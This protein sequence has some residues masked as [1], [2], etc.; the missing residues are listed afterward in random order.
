MKAADIYYGLSSREVRKFA[1]QY[2]KILKRNI[3]KS[4]HDKEIAGVDWFTL[5]L[6]RHRN[7]S[8]RK[9]EATSLARASAFNETNVQAFFRNWKTV[10]DRLKIGPNDIWNMDETGITTVQRPERIVARR[11]FK[12]IG[13]IVSSERGTLVTMALS[14]SATGNTVPPFFI[15]PRVHY[16]DHFI[17]NAPLGSSGSA[18]PSGWMKEEQFIQYA[19]HFVTHTKSS[20]ERPTVLLLDNHESHLSIEALD[21]LKNN[22]VTVLS[23]PPHCSHKLQPLDRSVYGPLKHYIN[24]ASDAWITL[25]PGRT[26]TIYDVPGIVSSCLDYAASPANIKAGFQ[27]TGIWP[28]NENIFLANEFLPAFATDRSV[29]PVNDAV[30]NEPTTSDTAANTET[31]VQDKMNDNFDACC[32]QHLI[33]EDI[34]PFPKADPRKKKV[35]PRRRSTAILTD[36]PIKELLKQTLQ[37]KKELVNRK[38]KRQLF[39]TQKKASSN[40]NLKNKVNYNTNIAIEKEETYCLCCLD[41]Y[42]SSAPGEIWIQCLKCKLWA[43]ESCAS[44]KKRFVCSNCISDAK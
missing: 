30:N 32:N 22:G 36:T 42:S 33:L 20:K 19:K 38:V 27:V 5:F 9:P 29:V 15:F 10:L 31:Q 40:I 6:K 37:A 3:P 8:I 13:R 4:W 28:Y 11:N 7:L 34:R 1:Y 44:K 2:A 35:H 43:H 21:F 14:V 24:R 41:S 26:M 23:F 12:Q 17:N 18:N 39:N 16:R 25:H